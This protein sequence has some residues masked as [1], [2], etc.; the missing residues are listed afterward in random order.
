MVKAVEVVLVG[1]GETVVV[2]G[3]S[4]DRPLEVVEHGGLIH[5]DPGV[6]DGGGGLQE[7]GCV[8]GLCGRGERRSK[9]GRSYKPLATRGPSK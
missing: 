1:V 5:V 4:R 8:C 7:G 3:V 9:T 2:Q 6:E